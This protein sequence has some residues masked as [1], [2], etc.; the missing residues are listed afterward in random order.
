MKAGAVWRRALARLAPRLEGDVDEEAL[1]EIEER[2]VAA[3]FGVRASSRLRSAVERAAKRDGARGVVDLG[4]ILAG[5]ISGIFAGDGV[6]ELASAESP[7]AVCMVVGVNGVG[8]TTTVARLAH[9]LAS[10]GHGVV[11]AAADTYRAAA[12]EQLVRLVEP[13]G[14]HCVRGQP[15][16]DPAAVAFDALDAARARGADHLVVDTAGRLHTSGGLMEQLAK[17]RRVLG[18]RH[19]AAPHEA[20]LVID[21]TVGQNAVAQAREFSRFVEL[22]G[23]VVA[24]M[25][26]TARGGVVVAIRQEVGIPVRYVGVGEGLAD[27]E[28]FD[29][30]AFARAVADGAPTDD[31]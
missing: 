11:V 20:L 2:L 18:A 4:R 26:S 1:D 29:P 19:E 12:A 5:E 25:D 27:L 14:A 22:T 16:G 6:R 9:R 23:V 15:G 24:K 21:A 30:E 28:L 8:K 3:D 31:S 10:E 17:I 13:T 7:P